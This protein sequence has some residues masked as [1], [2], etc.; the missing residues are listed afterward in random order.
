M[1]I[2]INANYRCGLR[3]T[4]P[5][6]SLLVLP[7]LPDTLDY[8][9]VGR[10]LVLRDAEANLIVDYIVG[11]VPVGVPPATSRGERHGN[12]PPRRAPRP[13]G[14]ARTAQTITLPNK[15]G[16]VRFAVMGDTG[17]GDARYKTAK[18]MDAVRAKF[19]F[20]FVVMVGDNIYG[21]DTPPTT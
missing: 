14:R 12:H 20:T 5:A 8:R 21:A 15:D 10:D 3:V 16:S 17:Q 13:A 19:P 9:F 1:P 6:A 18:M 11:A 7:P 4:V 2:R